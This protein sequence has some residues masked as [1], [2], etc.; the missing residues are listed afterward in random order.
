DPIKDIE[1]SGDRDLTF[2]LNAPYSPLFTTTFSQIL[3]LP[4]HI[5]EQY[6][7]S[8]QS[9][10]NEKPIGS[11][12]FR[13]DYWRKGQEVSLKANPDHFHAPKVD[14]LGVVFGNLDAVFQG[15]V[16][17]EVDINQSTLLVNQWDKLPQSPFLTG[18]ESDDW[19]VYYLG[20]NL[21]H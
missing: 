10:A 16:D 7:D 2:T 3:I 5:W 4:S 13:W 15:M 11:G 1:V 18:N 21:R 9:F 19:G 12:P 8:P 17:Q 20:F 14:F 6:K